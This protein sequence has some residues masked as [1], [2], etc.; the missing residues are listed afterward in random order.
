MAAEI[1]DHQSNLTEDEFYE[2]L[3]YMFGDAYPDLSEEEIE[4][5]IEELLDELPESYAESVFDTISNIGK[6]IGSG[7]LQLA[8]D[9]PELLK[10][11]GMIVGG[12]YGGP[13]G[14]KIGSGVGGYLSRGAQS[15]FNNESGK[16][17]AVIQ[18]PQTQ[19]ALARATLGVGNG[20]APLTIDGKTELVPVASYLRAMI[21]SA[22]GALQELDNKNIVPP[23]QLTESMPYY[24]DIDRQAEW[25]AEQLSQ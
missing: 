10:T 8:G 16:A 20:T 18:N 22:Q 6:K 19:A 17:L 4:E 3:L 7:G 14:A 12:I 25:L 21:S 2:S 5:Y 23:Q 11:A 1:F 9:N 24:E 15:G 13:V